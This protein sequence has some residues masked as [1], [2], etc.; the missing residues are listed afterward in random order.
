MSHAERHDI[1]SSVLSE[2]KERISMADI[3][4]E[5]IVYEELIWDGSI[6]PAHISVS[7][8]H[9]NVT[10]SGVTA[11]DVERRKA[12]AVARAVA[13]VRSVDNRIS[14]DPSAERVDDADLVASARAALDADPRVPKGSIDVTAVDG[15]V[16]MSGHVQHPFQRRAAE[17]VVRHLAGLQGFADC[18]TVGRGEA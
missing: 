6:D 4:L 5:R 17:G 11:T 14:V 12:G 3:E 18:V 13:G 1:I 9:G 10:L 2:S 16:T 8:D 7:A 15:L